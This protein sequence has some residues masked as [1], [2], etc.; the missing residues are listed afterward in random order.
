MNLAL[1]CRLLGQV[2]FLIGGS[3][4]MSLPWALPLAGGEW[5]YERDGFWGLLGA[6]AICFGVGGILRF[7]GRR[8]SGQLFRKEA[9]AIVGLSWVL[10]TLL[11]AML[12]VLSGDAQQHRAGLRRDR[13][14]EELHE[15]HRAEQGAV[16]L[17]DDARPVGAFRDHRLV[18]AE[19]L[20]LTVNSR[21]E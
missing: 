10:A 7:L 12:F 16:H 18:R 5:R 1:L 9:M 11:G 2:A 17:A 19:L 8:A 21:V 6:M 4:T 14:D 3:M 15:L 20:A 13:R